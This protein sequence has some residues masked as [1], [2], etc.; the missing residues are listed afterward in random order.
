MYINFEI[1]RASTIKRFIDVYAALG[2]KNPSDNII[3]L[4]LRGK[5]KPLNELVPT[6]VKNTKEKVSMFLS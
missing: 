3:A 2:V 4:N 1:D 5:A 6:L